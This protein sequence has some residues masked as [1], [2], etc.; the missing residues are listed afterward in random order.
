M[1]VFLKRSHNLRAVK[2]GKVFQTFLYNFLEIIMG[3]FSQNM[4]KN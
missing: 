4:P 1:R 2:F 3:K